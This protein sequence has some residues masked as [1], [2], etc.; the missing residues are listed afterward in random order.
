[1]MTSK[2]DEATIVEAIKGLVFDEG[3]LVSVFG[4]ESCLMTYKFAKQVTFNNVS[5]E[6]NI[7]VGDAQK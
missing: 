1:M 6:F 5:D 3:K 4:S 7:H 2:F